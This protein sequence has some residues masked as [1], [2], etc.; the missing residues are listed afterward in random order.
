M[1]P[2]LLC[3]AALAGL[4]EQQQATGAPAMAASGLARPGSTQSIEVHVGN[5][6]RTALLRVPRRWRADAGG[7]PMPLVLNWHGMLETPQEQQGL[8]DFDRVSDEHG[9]ILAYPQVCQADPLAAPQQCLLSC[10][11]E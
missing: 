5:L 2:A 7:G 6:T 9:F 4:L 8:S 10:A 1:L 11:A 3:C